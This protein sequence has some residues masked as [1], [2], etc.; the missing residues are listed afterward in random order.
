[1]NFNILA[2]N[3]QIGR[4]KLAKLPSSLK[5]LAMV[6][7]AGF[8]GSPL[9]ATAQ[10][11]SAEPTNET[12]SSLIKVDPG[13]NV[14][15]STGKP[16]FY[17]SK[18]GETVGVWV[19]G[20]NF[21][22]NAATVP[23]ESPT[24]LQVGG[25]SRYQGGKADS[26]AQDSL[27]GTIRVKQLH[28][29]GGGLTPDLTVAL[30]GS[31]TADSVF[32]SDSFYAVAGAAKS[33][34]V[35]ID[36]ANSTHETALKVGGGVSIQRNPSFSGGTL[37][38]VLQNS[39]SFSSGGDSYFIFEDPKDRFVLQ[40]N[41]SSDGIKVNKDLYLY[42]SAAPVSD[43]SSESKGA[44]IKNT[45]VTVGNTFSFRGGEGWLPG[46][47]TTFLQ[48]V[49]DPGANCEITAQAFELYSLTSENSTTLLLGHGAKLNAPKIYIHAHTPSSA[50][51]LMLGDT[52]SKDDNYGVTTNFVLMDGAG[53]NKI[54]FNNSHRDNSAEEASFPIYGVGTVEIQSGRT[55]FT[56]ISGYEGGTVID[57]GSTL[58]LKSVASAGRSSITNN[59]ELIY[60]GA[61]GEI[62][63]EISGFGSVVF[64]DNARIAMVKDAAWKGSTTVN[65]AFVSMGSID[66]LVHVASSSVTLFPQAVLRGF[67]S[68]EGSLNN[69]GSFIVG[70]SENKS[71]TNF[72]IHGNVTNSGEI[73]LGNGKIAGNRLTVNGNYTG[74]D[75]LIV[76][77]TE[78]NGDESPTDMLVIKGNSEGSTRV[79]IVNVGGNGKQ[80]LNGIEL[81]D[82]SGKSNG[83]FKQ[84]GRI[85]AGA[86][87]Y[88]LK[89]GTGANTNNWYLTSQLSHSKDN[90]GRDGTGDSGVID[91]RPENPSIDKLLV[92][93]EIGAYVGNNAA[94]RAL[95]SDRL[96]DRVGD[97][98]YAEPK[99]GD[100][101][102][103]SVWIRQRGDYSSWK[104][105]T[106]Q[107][108][109]RTQMYSTQLGADVHSWTSN[110]TDRFLIGWLVGYGH[111][112]TKSHS[113]N[114]GYHAK[115]L[116]DGIN[117][118]LTGT[119]FQ[120]RLNHEGIYID[121]WLTYSWFDNK[122]KGETLRTEK[123]HSK[124][125]SASVE[126]GYTAK[127]SDSKT[128]SGT[129][130]SWYLQPQAQIIWS[131]VKTDTLFEANGTN[132]TSKGH[133]NIQTRLGARTFVNINSQAYFNGTAGTQLFLEGN[134]I[135]NTK[136]PG[137]KMNGTALEQKGT[138]NLGEVKLGLNGK[139]KQNLQLW[140]NATAQAG[141]NHYR[142]LTCMMGL[143]YSF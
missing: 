93:P 6:V 26:S 24:L 112:N 99:E 74:S 33:V 64:T 36:G 139:L 80:T 111:A 15:V 86:Y 130:V 107:T 42:N 39:G 22:D 114:S 98:W 75:G 131:G 127:L 28:T 79:Q 106:G 38:F 141:S 103:A 47:K 77:N 128:A 126:S 51:T 136:N 3:K 37:S 43:L 97:L 68:I 31:S 110:G 92:R 19:N 56:R 113:V 132:V 13:Q 88:R 62:P 140:T 49:N 101:R 81:I 50:A 117:V 40:N 27:G 7:A 69:A 102:T 20:G 72:V 142:D 10:T 83:T 1:M 12:I 4:E 59:G 89:R 29:N 8:F 46:V 58:I 48:V 55:V 143:K 25:F 70:D 9:T 118:G 65:N 95:F 87:D 67:G 104:E 115:G 18:P 94:I 73:E 66:N 120:D 119:W 34:D 5:Y 78:L 60:S 14:T 133:N 21:T 134:W 53:S 137:V 54:I 135:H 30:F 45:N 84:E 44:L 129:D 2:Q 85:V 61:Q 52:T 96:Y 16:G 124:G 76:F 125:L 121:S 11:T 123:Y 35:M 71:Q 41:Q 57:N 63:N 122:I 116:V 100:T 23:L 32:F 109:N 17:S 90:S 105:S 108:K 82:V 91:N 138:R